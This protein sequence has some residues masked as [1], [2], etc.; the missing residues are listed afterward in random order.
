MSGDYRRCE[1]YKGTDKHCTEEAEAFCRFC[2][3]HEYV[4]GNPSLTNPPDDEKPKKQS[5]GKPAFDVLFSTPIEQVAAVFEYGNQ[6]YDERL[7][8]RKAL[9]LPVDERVEYVEKL[10]AAALRHIRT[11]FQAEDCRSVADAESKLP[12]LAHAIA[13]L[14]MALDIVHHD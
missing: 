8:W 6:K 12:H 4:F 13:D 11:Q 5:D 2:R 14:L 3:G 9:E 1:A 10:M 7:Q